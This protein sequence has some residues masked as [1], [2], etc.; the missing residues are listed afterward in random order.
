MTRTVV[1]SV[2]VAKLAQ[3]SQSAVSR[4]FTP[5]ASVSAKTREKVLK[6]AEELGYRPNAIAR[7]MISGRS[8]LIAVMVAYLENQFY[9][10]LIE[11]L[12]RELQRRGYH[13][14]F[15]ITDPGRQDMIVQR[16]LEYR[17]EG[18]V[19][20]SATLSSNL[21]RQCGE[22]GIPVVMLNRY[23]S[24]LSASRVISDNIEGGRLAAEHLVR[25]GHKRI[26]Y[27]AGLENSSTNRDREAGFQRGL[28]ELG[29]TLF[30]RGGGEYSFAGAA[31]AVRQLFAKPEQPDA[32]FCANDHMAFAAMDVIRGELG[33][34][35]PE[36]VSVI[37]YDDVPE[38][39]WAGYALTTIAQPVDAMVEAAATI[40]FDQVKEKSVKRRAAV[41]PAELVVRASTR[42]VFAAAA[43]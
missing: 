25:G 3:V 43:D 28:A 24:S 29:V 26:A 32:L 19:M 38:A 2:D 39:S 10:I 40:L 13:V 11:R 1:T 31:E 15:F 33:L 6:A 23:V 12:S 8:R 34:R 30:D 20:A 5:G 9:P 16:I 21:A 36:D 4:T 37:G 42:P 14:L 22:S 18:I 27:L 35:I 7:A 17:V 41:I